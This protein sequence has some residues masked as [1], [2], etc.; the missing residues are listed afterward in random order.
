AFREAVGRRFEHRIA[1]QYVFQDLAPP[2]TK[3]WG[4]GHAILMAADVIA[5]PFGVINADDFYGAD[6]FRLLGEHLRAGDSNAALVGFELRNTLSEFGSVSR[7]VCR[8]TDGCLDS[9]R[10]VVGIERHAVGAS[11]PLRGDELVSMNMWGFGPTMFDRLREQ[12]REFL[13]AR[14]SDGK[15]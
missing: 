12:W 3:P 8:V 4:T 5:A 9:V 11:H 10:E 1:V 13:E 2:R 15:A 14:S 7:V 6:S